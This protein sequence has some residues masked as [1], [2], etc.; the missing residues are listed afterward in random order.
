MNKTRI[1]RIASELQKEISAI[2]NGELKDSRIAPITSVTEVDLTDDLQSAKIYISVMGTDWEKKETIEGLKHSK[3]FIKREL[4][5][6]M[7]LRHI[8]ELIFILDE[9]LEKAMRMEKLISEVIKKD[10]EA[11]NE[12]KED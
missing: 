11:Q 5:K 4:G 7:N 6:N 12:R 9:Q 2:I 3:G 10:N 8:P 1:R